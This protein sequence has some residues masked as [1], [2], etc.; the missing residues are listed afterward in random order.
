MLFL[1]L[2]ALLIALPALLSV[3]DFFIY[4][5]TGDHLLSR[6]LIVLIEVISFLILPGL[7]VIVHG[8]NECCVDM[9]ALFAPEHMLSISVIIACCVIS[10]FYSS[11][12]NEIACPIVEIMVN[13]S[14][15]I[16]II[17]NIFIAIQVNDI[18]LVLGGILPI[19]LLTIMVLI[20]NHKTFMTFAQERDFKTENF[21][22][23]LAWEILNAHPLMKFTVILIL[24]FP[25]IFMLTVI[26]LLFG[27][28]PDSLIR[29]FTET[30][31]Q[32]FSQWDYKCE[33][34]ECGGHYLC[35]VAANGHTA[36]VKPQ[37]WGI[38]HGHDIICN[39][40]LLIS[41]AFE[42]LLQENLPFLHK[43]IRKQY[44]KVGDLIIKKYDIFNNKY[45]S[46]FIYII[47]K[48]LEW[49]F[50]LTLYTFDKNPENRIAKQYI[51]ASDR[52]EMNKN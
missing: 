34:V 30:Y 47:M 16:G 33:N 13:A 46:D 8:P 14:L 24:C 21:I 5:M 42:D 6:P 12:R 26:L 7:Y 3:F 4:I 49:F 28:K 41:N 38:R 19:F 20:K 37:R 23:K 48:P 17:L 40:Q 43:N 15:V 50:V 36:L 2:L 51:S 9:S 27:Q 45:F 18:L 10:Y 25:I 35:S 31:K 39:R 29:A 32:G 44:D 11:Y 52:Q 1:V 22:I